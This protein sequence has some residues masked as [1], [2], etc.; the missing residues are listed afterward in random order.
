MG[1]LD[2]GI[3]AVFGQ[4]F[5]SLYL[6]ATLIRVTL[7]EDGMGGYLPPVTESIPARGQLDNADKTMRET[8]GFVETDMKIILLQS[9]LAVTPTTDDEIIIRGI[10]WQI[11]RIRR[12]PADSQWVIHGK[13]KL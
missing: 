6:P 7:T 5:G 11:F 4:A 3:R 9:G 8:P 12:D 13:R 2:G 1:A 10:T